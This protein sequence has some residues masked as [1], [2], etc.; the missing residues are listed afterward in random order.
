M[1]DDALHPAKPTR[2]NR[3]LLVALV[4][5][6]LV[7]ILLARGY[8]ALVAERGTAAT[9][10]QG[11]LIEPAEPLAA[12]R[13]N[14]IDGKPLHERL[15]VGGWTL[16]HLVAA[17]CEETC[18]RNLYNTRQVRTGLNKDMGRVRRL[19]IAPYPYPAEGLEW[20]HQQHPR[21]QLATANDEALAALI[22][23]L[24]PAAMHSS[25]LSAHRIYL[26]DPHGNL[27]M[28]YAPDQDPKG[29]LAD[30]RK[31]LKVSQIG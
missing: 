21:L 28:W 13:L 26:V 10:N 17:D 3:L 31:L 5:A 29:I 9:T 22:Q 16:V 8:Y 12:L 18:R 27:M 20:L 24:P 11:V 7:P 25:V 14:G 6:F 2:R 19:L 4:G 30:L 15:L 23:K 1:A